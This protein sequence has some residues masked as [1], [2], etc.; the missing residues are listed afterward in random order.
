MDDVLRDF[1]QQYG[2]HGKGTEFLQMFSDLENPSHD[3]TS[4]LLLHGNN[5]R[6]GEDLHKVDGCLHDECKYFRN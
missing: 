3:L 4:W 6:D 1:I 2:S 5:V